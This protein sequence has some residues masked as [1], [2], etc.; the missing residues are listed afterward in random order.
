MPLFKM[1]PA[2]QAKVYKGLIPMHLRS[3]MQ[4]VT[5]V[6][7]R[8]A[9]E[10]SRNRRFESGDFT[11]R[12]NATGYHTPMEENLS[13]RSDSPFGLLGSEGEVDVVLENEVF[14]TTIES[15]STF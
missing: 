10:N 1:D 2:R 9:V 12:R 13:P 11:L 15:N 6:F 4:D 14:H 7:L 3:R 5:E 8:G